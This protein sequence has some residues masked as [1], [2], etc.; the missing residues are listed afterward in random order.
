MTAMK[1]HQRG[2]HLSCTAIAQSVCTEQTEPPCPPQKRWCWDPRLE[3]VTPSVW[4]VPRGAGTG[5][6]VLEGWPQELAGG[7]E[8]SRGPLHT[9][10]AQGHPFS[11]SLF[12]LSL[13]GHLLCTQVCI[14]P[15]RLKNLGYFC[16]DSL[17]FHTGRL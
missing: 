9:A 4:V 17:V 11:Y 7:T 12:Q 2:L 5:Q 1:G 8:S 3:P 6:E 14:P 15:R 13:P 16:T 10:Q